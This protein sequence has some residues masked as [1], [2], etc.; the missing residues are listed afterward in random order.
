VKKIGQPPE[1]AGWWELI[2][3]TRGGQAQ[4]VEGVIEHIHSDG[5]FEAYRNGVRIA[6]G[7]HV[8]FQSDPPGFTNV[9]EARHL[10]GVS[11]REL[12]LYRFVGQVLEVCKAPESDGRPER[13]ESVEGTS[14]VQAAIRRISHTDPRIVS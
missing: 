11:G 3:Y 6:A 14:I 1:F 7:R 2:S 9:Q 8:D 10:L 4:D 13:F 12:A 5:R